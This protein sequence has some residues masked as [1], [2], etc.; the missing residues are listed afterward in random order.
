MLGHEGSISKVPWP[1]SDASLCVDTTV[2]MAVQVNGKVRGKMEI[3]M[4]GLFCHVPN[5]LHSF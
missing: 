3:G 5:L 1:E 2:T 4:C